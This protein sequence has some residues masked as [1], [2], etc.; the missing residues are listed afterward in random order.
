MQTCT[1]TRPAGSLR[2][3]IVEDD[4]A[5]RHAVVAVIAHEPGMSVLAQAQTCAQARAMLQGP[6]ADVLL[7]DLGL[8]DGS[9][10]DVIRQARRLWDDCDIMVNTMFGDEAHVMRS[11]EAGACGYL[12]KDSEPAGI[13]RD[14]R[15]LRDGGSPINPLIARQL[16]DR[17]R[18]GLPAAAPPAAM[19]LSPREHQ[20]LERI[21]LGY[22]YDEI[23]RDLEVSRHTVQT[24]V[25]R[26]YRKL[27]VHSK[28]DAINAARGLCP[29]G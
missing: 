8:P 20:V 4:P 19:A 14:I 24:F 9:G 21:T 18:Q 6:P 11:I 3:A 2:I 29:D 13:V 22:T 28:V 27:Q 12:L 7:V 25:R 5:F 17:L 1:P 15:A 10:I 16:L 26:I 23:A